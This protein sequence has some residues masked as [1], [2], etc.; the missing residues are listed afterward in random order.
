MQ[1]DLPDA[2]LARATDDGS[3]AARIAGLHVHPLKSGAALSFDAVRLSPTGFEN[4]RR[5][6]LVDPSGEFFSQREHPRM[7]LLRAVVEAGRL[8]LAA[9]GLPPLS[10]PV[11]PPLA[12][13]VPVRVWND[14]FDALPVDP[15][16]DRWCSDFLGE[17]AR[18]VV[19]HPAMHRPSN[20]QRT[21]DIEALNGFADG[22]PILVLSTG[23]LAELNRRLAGQG[24]PAVAMA[25]FRP[26]LVLD[27]L[28]AHAEDHLDELHI[29]TDDGPVVLRLVKPCPRCPMPDVDPAT[30]LRGD[31]PGPTLAN[32]RADPRLDG[33]ITFGMNAVI[34][35]G[36][37]RMLR[38]GQAVRG[39]V[40]F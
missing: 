17:P 18:L 40:R 32:Y 24:K 19:T 15:A 16:A 8:H 23:S 11:D 35:E 29:P 28:D 10:V 22:Y 37:G 21:G 27:G 3:S 38:V 6:M 20:R 1:N 2:D 33:A 14:A 7:A 30:G 4:D 34:V 12:R 31:E 9:P 26:N 25:R 5:W 39:T 13:G 36:I